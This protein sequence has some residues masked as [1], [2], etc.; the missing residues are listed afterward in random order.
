MVAAAVAAIGCKDCETLSVA[1]AVVKHQVEVLVLDPPE[2]V[3]G[4]A[5]METDVNLVV[6]GIDWAIC[7]W[8]P[9]GGR[10]SGVC[11]LIVLTI[12]VQKMCM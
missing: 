9:G 3:K 8:V 4:V 5:T 6:L 1:V 11:S 10:G 2:G 12:P 7:D